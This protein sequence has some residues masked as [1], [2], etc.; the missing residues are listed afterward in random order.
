MEEEIEIH[1]SILSWKIP[2][3]KKPGGL[4]SMGCKES[5]VTEQLNSNDKGRG[6]HLDPQN[7]SVTLFRKRI[8]RSDRPG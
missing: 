1:F 2:W 6:S 4:Q 3:I 5:D 7:A 8:L